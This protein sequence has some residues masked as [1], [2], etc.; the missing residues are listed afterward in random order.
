MIV[1]ALTDKGE[2]LRGAHPLFF[3]LFFFFF[4]RKDLLTVINVK[5]VNYDEYPL[6][7]DWLKRLESRASVKYA[8]ELSK[9][10]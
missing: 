8:V 3:F 6:V 2:L 10:A 5:V 9:S 1:A 7:K 4:S